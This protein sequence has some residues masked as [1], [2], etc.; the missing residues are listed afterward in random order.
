MIKVLIISEGTAS[1]GGVESHCK[2]LCQLLSDSNSNVV[3]ML[4]IKDIK[5]YKIPL[6]RKSIFNPK[7]LSQIIKNSGCDVV[8]A[9]GSSSFAIVQT[10]RA[11]KKANKRVVYSPHF[12]P[13]TYI[14]RSFLG[15]M[16]F[17]MCVKPALKK[18]DT[19]VTINNEDTDFF[20]RY[21]RKVVKIPHWIERVEEQS[22]KRE[23]NMILFV[24]RNADNK[25]F[26]H[27]YQMPMGKYQVHCV[28]GGTLERKDFIQHIGISK[29]ELDN[30]Y[31]KA[32]LLVVPS[33]YE[34][35][36]LVALE[37]LARG[38]PILLSDRVRIADHLPQCSYVRI[39]KYH[40]FNEF[41]KAIDLTKGQIVDVSTV[42]N[43]FNRKMIAK[44]YE[45]SVYC[46]PV[47]K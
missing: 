7:E 8:H 3:E 25:G 12:H 5:I 34:A 11:A 47:K 17:N 9:H 1:I 36:S 16:F 23:D 42:K 44:M 31:R 46:K 15:E 30:L 38:C 45:E 14:R 19:V 22:I 10:I 37:A 39:F 27:L 18:I 29:E 40:N 32:S 2:D 41:N 20:N 6:I 33:R 4:P 24:G 28:T 13:F 21:H 26:E 35:F 43:I